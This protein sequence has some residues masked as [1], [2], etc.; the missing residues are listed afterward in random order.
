MGAVLDWFGNKKV[1]VTLPK[2]HLL[3]ISITFVMNG[4]PGDKRETLRRK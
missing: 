1:A 3:N 4:Q 2:L